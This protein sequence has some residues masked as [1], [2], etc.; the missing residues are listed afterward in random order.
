M[1]F[2]DGQID[3]DVKLSKAFTEFIP[4]LVRNDYK[5]VTSVPGEI[6]IKKG[7]IDINIK[8]DQS[9]DLSVDKRSDESGDQRVLI[10]KLSTQ[11]FLKYS[12]STDN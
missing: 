10:L 6:T 9:A 8:Y 12:I 4:L 11:D 3:V 7:N 2:K 1:T 5:V